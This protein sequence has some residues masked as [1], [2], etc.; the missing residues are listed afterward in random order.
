MLYSI[1]ATRDAVVKGVMIGVLVFCALALVIALCVGAKK[2]VRRVSWLGVTWLFTGLL[3][4]LLHKFIGG[5]LAG[6][7]SPLTQKIPLADSVKAFAPSLVL[8]S[9]CLLIGMLV[10]GIMALVLRP[11]RKYVRKEADVFTKDDDWVEY[12]DEAEDYDDYEK[13]ASRKLVQKSG[14]AKPSLMGRVFGSLTCMI[15]C[16]MVLATVILFTLFVL[17]A[18][19]FRDTTFASLF[20][21]GAVNA[22]VAFTKNYALD[23]LMLGI[24]ISFLLKGRK[25]GFIETIRAI[26]IYLGGI[27]LVVFCFYIPFSKLCH[28]PSEGGIWLFHKIVGAT[29]YAVQGMAG[30]YAPI[31]GGI[32]AG[33]G[34][35][36]VAILAMV[37]LNLV[38]KGL[39]YVKDSWKPFR[40]IDGVFA[41]LLYFVIALAVCLLFW[42]VFTLFTHFGLLHTVFF[43]E[44][45]TLA[46]GFFEI[47]QTY[48]EPL[49]QMAEQY[50]AGLFAK[51]GA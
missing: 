23:F 45:T 34:M 41:V 43:T 28:A 22:V 20:S 32:F 15:N 50:L 33:L 1:L 6:I 39:I 10:H 37:L 36:I 13:Y 12:D 27:A 25:N 9:A 51:F 19:P 48:F 8:A 3:F 18:T 47:C 44:K 21:I 30:K 7:L 11:K 31:V 46:G 16:A 26:V 24:A 29:V 42:A 40:V 4:C 35:S 38:F 17:Q 2:G 14:Y 49:I 5:W